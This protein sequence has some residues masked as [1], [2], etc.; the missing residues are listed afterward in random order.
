MAM[1][2]ERFMNLF[3]GYELAHGHDRSDKQHAKMAKKSGRYQQ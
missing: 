1:I 2:E 3:R